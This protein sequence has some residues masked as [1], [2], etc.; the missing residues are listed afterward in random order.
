MRR[1]MSN[2]SHEAEFRIEDHISSAE[3]SA[4]RKCRAVKAE[5]VRSA[6]TAALPAASIRNRLTEVRLRRA[7]EIKVAPISWLWP[8]WFARGKMHILGGQ[9]GAGKT[10]LAM[11]IGATVTAGG[12]WPDGTR[13][14]EGNVIIWSGEDDPVDTL[15]PRLAVS[16]AD[17]ARVYFVGDVKEKGRR[18]PFDP[19]NDIPALKRAIDD[20]G[21]A[22]LIVVDPIV[23]AVACDSHKN[24]ETRACPPTPCGLSR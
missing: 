13:V 2:D 6:P 24:S 9:P 8:G 22:G 20:A 17:L 10:T 1:S 18:R 19:A 21:G 12:L 15:I 23:S 5:Q 11:K 16:G 4:S 3:N 7:S 14:T